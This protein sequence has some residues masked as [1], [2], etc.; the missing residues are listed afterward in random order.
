MHI[1][2]ETSYIFNNFSMSIGI[3]PDK[4]PHEKIFTP[5]NMETGEHQKDTDILTADL[6]ALNDPQSELSLFLKKRGLSEEDLEKIKEDLEKIKEKCREA[7][8][9]IK[10]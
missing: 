1:K 6:K 10:S 8:R 3:Y 4:S 5:Q 7:I 9:T 2:N